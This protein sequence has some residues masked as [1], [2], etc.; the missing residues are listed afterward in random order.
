MYCNSLCGLPNVMSNIP[1]QKYSLQLISSVSRKPILLLHRNSSDMRE[2]TWIVSFHRMVWFWEGTMKLKYFV[3]DTMSLDWKKFP[4]SHCK[5][6][7]WVKDVHRV[8]LTNGHYFQNHQRQNERSQG[9]LNN[10]QTM[11]CV[12]S[13]LRSPLCHIRLSVLRFLSNIQIV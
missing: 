6:H 9:C 3:V 13:E 2:K 10:I 1:L 5:A 7:F 11:I 4:L 12:S 8:S